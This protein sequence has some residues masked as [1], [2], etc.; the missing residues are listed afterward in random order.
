MRRM[1]RN[2]STLKPSKLRRRRQKL[3]IIKTISIF[4]LLICFIL[5]FSWLSKISLIQIEEIEISGNI[6]VSKEEIIETVKKETSRK[7]LMLF[8][9]NNIFL[10]PK[11]AIELKLTSEFKKLDKVTVKSRG[12]KKLIVKIVE[13]T[14][15]SLWCRDTIGSKNENNKNFETCYFLDEEG[16]IFSGAP[17]F[18]GNSFVRNYGLLDD[19][20]QPIGEIYMSNK[21]FK[22]VSSFMNS[23]LILGIKVE[24]FRVESEDDYKIYLKNGIKLIFDNKQSLDKT[25]ENIQ[26]ILSE[27]DLRGDYPINNLTKIDYIDF[28]FGNKI[29]LKTE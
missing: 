24:S 1:I 7:Y 17:D 3:F 21:K 25:L 5:A 12:F 14:P 8:S 23:L 20:E 26:S 4:F 18:S 16:L 9:R 29:F 15:N 27:V 2:N 28:R 13:R 19:I 11:K 10:Y 22:D 6:I